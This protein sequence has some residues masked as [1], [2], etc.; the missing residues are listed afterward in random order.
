MLMGREYYLVISLCLMGFLLFTALFASDT[1]IGG[2]KNSDNPRWDI[3]L[4]RILD[5]KDSEGV[6]YPEGFRTLNLYMKANPLH[7]APHVME[8]LPESDTLGMI[9]LTRLISEASTPVIVVR[10]E[11]SELPGRI[12]DTLE[13]SRI[14]ER[15]WMPVLH[16][17]LRANLSFPPELRK[18]AEYDESLMLE[19]AGII[20]EKDRMAI[21]V[22][23]HQLKN[24]DVSRIPQRDI[25]EI[26]GKS[27]RVV[28]RILSELK[29]A[30]E[31]KPLLPTVTELR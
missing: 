15:R 8:N 28:N 11:A 13:S 20:K 29:N 30:T 21:S 16:N 9:R 10:A 27:M 5:R 14:P 4:S 17:V 31:E 23:V 26:S 12:I 1:E 25:I 7:L 19:D 2:H 3:R 18:L 6:V 22:L 24:L